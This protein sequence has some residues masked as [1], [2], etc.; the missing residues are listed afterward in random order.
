[1]T[2]GMSISAKRL[3]AKVG[4]QICSGLDAKYNPNNNWSN[5][6]LMKVQQAP[7]LFSSQIDLSEPEIFALKIAQSRK[8]GM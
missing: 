5:L 3:N 1:M 2:R 4:L 6:T 8:G 7:A